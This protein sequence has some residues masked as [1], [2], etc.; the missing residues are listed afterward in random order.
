MQDQR[1][2]TTR[3]ITQQKPA[4]FSLNAAEGDVTLLRT[5]DSD[6]KIAE[7]GMRLQGKYKQDTDEHPLITVITVVFNGVE[8][9]EETI[10]SVVSQTYANVEFI[11]VDG[12]STDGTL[13]IIRKYEYFIDYWVSE[14]DKGIF[15]AM[16]K[17]IDLGSG[18]WINFMNAGDRFFSKETILSIFQTHKYLGIDI[19][20]GDHEVVYHNNRKRLSR[21]GLPVNLWKGS[22]FCHQATFIRRNY[23]KKNKFNIYTII[24]AD[25]EIFYKAFKNN[26]SFRHIPI[27]ICSYGA[28]GVSDINRIDYI[29]C[30]WNIVDKNFYINFYY[31]SRIIKEIIKMK[32]KKCFNFFQKV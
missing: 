12:G 18:Q 6:Q 4:W 27:V 11:I 9:L 19:I 5:P 21:G 15:D 20:Y 23:H 32:V 28:G 25:F 16:N 14:P 22:Q 7:G 3:C 17:G 29:V 13:N 8:H 2:A 1:Y 30:F 26:V 24:A 31:V 10:K